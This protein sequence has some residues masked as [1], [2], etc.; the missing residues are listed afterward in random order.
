MYQYPIDILKNEVDNGLSYY[1]C[2]FMSYTW[3]CLEFIL[4]KSWGTICDVGVACREATF[5]FRTM[6]SI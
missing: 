6:G 1:V 4:G 5:A 2:L 3:L